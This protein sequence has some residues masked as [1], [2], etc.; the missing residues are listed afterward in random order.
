VV[1]GFAL[2]AM[3]LGWPISAGLSGRVY[4]RIGMRDTALIGSV[5][6]ITGAVLTALLSQDASPWQ[7]AG[8]AF[9]VGVG[10][11]LS[12]SPM[13]VAV[14]SVVGW[15]RRGVVTGTNM[16]CR[17]LG[18]AVGV[19]VFGAIANATLASRLAN[20]PGGLAVPQGVDATSIILGTH[21]ATDPAVATFVRGALF[22]ATHLV[23]VAMIGIAVLSV[24]ALLLV[25]RKI[26]ELTFV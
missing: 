21:T 22:D 18:S 11:G 23:F 16:F 2:A 4:M 6:I 1:A 3:T 20:P 19:A 15:E 7:A 9:V 14:Q 13:V 10:L 25:P 26:K 24:G 12:S 8:A 17:S 5:F